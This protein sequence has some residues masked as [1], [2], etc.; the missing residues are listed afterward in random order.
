[1]AWELGRRPGSKQA[2]M[3]Q[4]GSAETPA[5]RK[6]RSRRR[7]P[8]Q[9]TPPPPPN[10]H[11]P[12]CPPDPSAVSNAS[13]AGFITP[14]PKPT[15]PHAHTHTQTTHSSQRAAT[16]NARAQLPTQ[17]QRHR[18]MRPCPA[19]PRRSSLVTSASNAISFAPPSPAPEN[20][21]VAARIPP[22]Y[23]P[24]FLGK[25]SGGNGSFKRRNG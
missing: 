3:G 24:N 2:D 6:R 4:R 18:P 8:R 20:W 23:A 14:D 21:L 15:H 17:R 16:A 11:P 7:S 10:R 9:H 5:L 1:M 12:P 25:N 13:S 22:E 19:L